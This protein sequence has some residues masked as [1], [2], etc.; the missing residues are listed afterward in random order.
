[1]QVASVT[2]AVQVK[3]APPVIDTSST[4]TGAVARQRAPEQ[5]SGRPAIQRRAVPRARRQ[6]RRSGRPG[7]S[8][9]CRRQRPRE[10]LRR[11]RREHHQR[12][13]RCARARTRS[14]SGRSAT[15]CRS[16]SSRRRRCKT[17][18]Y[19]A[20]FGQASGGVVNVI[21]KSGTNQLRGS[22]FGYYR[23]DDLE[24]SYDQVQT[25]NGTV[26]ITG[27]REDDFGAEAGGPIVPKQGC[28]SS[29]RSIRSRIARSTSR[30]TASRY[31][32]WGRCLK[33]A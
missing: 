23:P 10:Q 6:Q 5:R 30:R 22:L 9:D 14:C 4:T 11:R 8:V 28:S 31:R 19:Q 18:G 12:R 13:L 7:Q 25:T 27:T 20:E 32:A 21:T 26:N 17:G 24:S 29:A 16:I 3:G 33:I 1:M 2:E 15:A